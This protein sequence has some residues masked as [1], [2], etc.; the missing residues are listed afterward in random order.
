MRDALLYT[1]AAIEWSLEL[2]LAQ[3]HSNVQ[4]NVQV[5]VLTR[6]FVCLLTIRR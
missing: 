5:G 4:L 1:L 2:W 6:P 3:I